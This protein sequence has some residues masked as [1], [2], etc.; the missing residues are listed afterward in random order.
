MR[1]VNVMD[2]DHDPTLGRL[3][4][5]AREELPGAEFLAAVSAR[6]ARARRRQRA[7]YV[8]TLAILVVGVALLAPKLIAGSLALSELVSG[9]GF[10]SAAPD[11]RVAWLVSLV[12][13]GLVLLWSR[14]GLRR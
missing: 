5:E 14:R 6:L 4:A 11:G 10:G 13:G 7:R 8:A 9:G 12:A 1:M 3:F 2:T